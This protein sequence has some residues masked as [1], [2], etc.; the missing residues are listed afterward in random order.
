MDGK[1]LHDGITACFML[2]GIILSINVQYDIFSVHH[3]TISYYSIK[4]YT[5]CL[6]YT[7]TITIAGNLKFHMNI[8]GSYVYI[9]V[10]TYVIVIAT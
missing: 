10:Y 5:N 2:Q 3:T 4:F 6:S 8:L 7:I 1:I 9:H